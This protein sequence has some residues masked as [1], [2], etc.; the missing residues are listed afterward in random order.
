[1]LGYVLL[2][3]G[4]YA[5]ICFFL[6]SQYVAPSRVP[7]IR[8]PELGEASIEGVPSWVSPQ[9][10]DGRAVKGLFVLA[11]GYGGAR[12]SWRD[13]A[14]RLT[15]DGYGVVVPSMPGHDENPDPACGFGTKESRLVSACVR[16]ADAKIAPSPKV[17]IVAV[18]V[19]MGG[20]AVWLAS[21]EE[22]R[23]N[24]VISEG[25]F[26]QCDEATDD[27]F[28]ALFPGAN[29]LLAPVR[30]IAQ[31]RTGIDPKSIRPIDA[32]AKWKGRPALVI[33]GDSDRL[34]P[35][36]NADRL[37]SASGAEL[38]IVPNCAHAQAC[39][40]ALD[41]YVKRLERMAR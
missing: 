38:W 32:A 37:A 40:V 18:G 8:P 1:M 15:K 14:V 9:L 39:G 29:F 7:S 28:R 20:A 12:A 31:I 24:A 23:I 36:S 2:V 13:L 26:A 25:A 33:H 30:W 4:F 34:I 19:S 27:W 35:R 3:I 17:K 16:W 41:D 22:P 10:L 11:H 21:A 5:G 6:A